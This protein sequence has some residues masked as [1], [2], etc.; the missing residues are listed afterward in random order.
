MCPL[1][2]GGEE[3]EGV[4]GVFSV[5]VLTTSFELRARSTPSSMVIVATVGA[6]EGAEGVTVRRAVVLCAGSTGV[7]ACVAIAG[8]V[9]IALA[10]CASGRF[11]LVLLD[12][13][14]VLVDVDTLFD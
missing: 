10:F 4:F 1:V 11:L 9:A 14:E 3:R 12:T 2:I 7:F 8:Y 13:D 6:A 5:D